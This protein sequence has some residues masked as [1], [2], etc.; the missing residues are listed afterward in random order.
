NFAFLARALE[1]ANVQVVWHTTV[2]DAAERIAE[3][4]GRAL[5]RADAVVMTGGL[6]PTPDDMT[7]KAVA[8]ALS[9]PLVL[10]ENVIADIRERMRKLGRKFPPSFE[11]QA[12][13]P[14]GAQILSNRLGS[15]PGLM[16]LAR[17]KPVFL[18]PGVPSEM[19]G[20]ATEF[21]IPMLS[22]RSGR[23]VESFTLRT[24]GIFETL[25]HEKIGAKPQ[26]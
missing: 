1:A 3:G 24:S 25:L 26:E 5:D 11:G 17:D 16:I 20:L 7:R 13:I 23:T 12:L 6:G 18:L 19:E 15:A 4:L 8:S 9:R 2:G 14:T 22:A 10:D 21:V